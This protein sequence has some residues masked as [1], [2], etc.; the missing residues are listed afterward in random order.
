M[1]FIAALVVVLLLSIPLHSAELLRAVPLTDHILLLHFSDGTVHYPNELMVNRLNTED[2]TRLTAYRISSS[3]DPRYRTGLSPV[4]IGRKSKGTKF[5]KGPDWFTVEEGVDPSGKPWSA[6]HWLY[7]VL[8][9][10]LL[11]GK[12]YSVTTGDLA[13]NG[14][15]W[16]FVFDEKQLRSEAV[17]TNTLGYHP[18]AP[19][20]AYVY[21]WMGDL[22][23]LALRSYA[24]VPFAVYNTL[25]SVTPVASGQL[26]FRKSALNP[27]TE[28]WHD[29][30]NRNFLG[31]DVYECDFSQVREPGQYY[32][33]VDNI[34]RSYD[35]RIGPDPV[36]EAYYH[37]MRALYHQRSGIRQAPPFVPVGFYRPV[38]QNAKVTDTLHSDPRYWAT[39]FAGQLNYSPF[40]F[41]HWQNHDNGGETA[42]AIR[43]SAEGHP[44]EVAG[45]Y[46]DAGDWDQYYTHERV[47]IILLLTYEYSQNRFGDNELNL[48]ESGNGVPDI[49]DEASW[50]VK[51]NYRL[52]KELQQKGY[53]DGGVGGARICPDIY[54][55]L[56]D[57]REVEENV[58]SWQDPR[59][60]VVSAADAFMTYFYAG[61]AAQLAVALKGVGKN[62]EKWPVEMLDAISWS[63]MSY[64]T[65]NWISEAEEAFRWASLPQNQP[66]SGGN[67]DSQLAAYRAYAAINLYRVT[68]LPAYQTIARKA[69]STL[70][71]DDKLTIDQR[72]AV[73]CYLLAD[74]ADVDRDF[75][76]RLKEI[77]VNNAHIYGMKA[78]ERRAC[79]WAGE[80]G[81]SMLIGQA[82]TPWILEVLI[83]HHITGDSTYWEAIHTTADYFLGSNPLHTTWMV[84]VGPNGL[85]EAFQLD[86]RNTGTWQVY[87]GWVPYG[88]WTLNHHWGLREIAID[89]VKKTG[90]IG[91]WDPHWAAFSNYPNMEF[92]PGHEQYNN[93]IH[94]PLSAENTVH[95][96]A[97]FA[98]IT[99]GYV[100]G[101][102]YHNRRTAQPITALV[103]DQPQLDMVTG[104]QV[105]L[106]AASSVSNATFARQR[107][108]SENPDVAHVDSYGRVTARRAGQASIV[109]ETLD[110]S[111]AARCQVT[112]LTPPPP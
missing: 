27:E 22:A 70:E 78:A 84:G 92:W 103:I 77:A 75:Q 28:K 112:V 41:T 1:K 62:P 2:A 9:H 57:N 88:P 90:G 15:T 66:D 25:D 89:G 81:M 74:N 23:G 8:P 104:E 105:L 83:A 108:Y 34:G 102:T 44:L 95:Q 46:H 45:W 18:D 55:D 6:E 39:S 33:S 59:P 20:Y 58:P 67:Y 65:V 13:T 97:V 38:N 48:P 85:Q 69:L 30:P 64:D 107:W 71:P 49:V 4:D 36:W 101:R 111:V 73:Y 29:T 98:G 91:P 110:Q 53:S 54:H 86:S 43:K 96:N 19:K 24:G 26:T 12:T 80:Y 109:C 5:A 56:G 51:F 94:A 68:G 79:R 52:R 21:Q 50:L 16:S 76:R 37:G 42:P 14:Q 87:D 47:P 11:T 106:G 63:E 35:F 17:H 82:T 32:V 7:L 61:Q 99:Y 40:P 3:D 100:N 93:N 31:A 60:Y 10:R 72:W